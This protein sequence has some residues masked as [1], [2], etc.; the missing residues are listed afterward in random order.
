[1]LVWGY[2]V[3]PGIAVGAFVLILLSG[4][5]LWAA[6]VYAAGTALSA[7][8][9]AFILR[10]IVKFDNTLSHLGD[11]VGLIVVGAFGGGVVSDQLEFQ[12]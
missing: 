3:W 5:P 6:V 11:V 1:M 12:P 8:L 10:R 7:L 9:P 4:L 2:S